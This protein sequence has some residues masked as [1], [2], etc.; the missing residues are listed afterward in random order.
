MMLLLR[1]SNA[2]ELARVRPFVQGLKE[3]EFFVEA[4]NESDEVS[5]NGDLAGS[6]FEMSG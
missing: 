5:H 6:V 3:D 1:T 4:G 2:M